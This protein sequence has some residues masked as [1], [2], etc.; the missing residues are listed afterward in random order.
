MPLDLDAF[1]RDYY[2]HLGRDPTAVQ[3]EIEA[4]S[5]QHQKETIDFVRTI[6]DLERLYPQGTFQYISAENTLKKM[7]SDLLHPSRSDS[8]Y[9]VLIER[10]PETGAYAEERHSR[11]YQT[12]DFQ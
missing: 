5:T 11:Q 3:R 12:A 1:S 10:D 7:L 4:A 2:E 6:Y 8:A 9:A